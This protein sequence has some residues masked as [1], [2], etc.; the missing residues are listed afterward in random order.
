MNLTTR[1]FIYAPFAVFV[2]LALGLSV[3]WWIAA[4]DYAARLDRANGREIAPSVTLHFASK[5]VG[6]FPFR[7]DAVFKNIEI[8]VATPHGPASWRAPDFAMHALTYGRDQTL[9][10]AAGRQEL[11][12]TG[13]DGRR[14]TLDFVPGALRASAILKDGAVSRFDLEIINWGSAA[15]TAA[16]AQLHL[17]RNPSHDAIDLFITAG[18][19]HLPPAERSAFGNEI[20]SAS[21]SVTI[22]PGGAFNGLRAGKSDWLQAV[23][24]WRGLSGGAHIDHVEIAWDRLSAMGEGALSL[25]G[26]HRPLGLVDLKFAGI[27]T[28]L[29]GA[30]RDHIAATA[31]K[32]VGAAL[33]ARTRV[34]GAD[35]MSRVGAV[36]AFKDGIAYVGD[37]PAGFVEPLY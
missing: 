29:A 24:D 16:D 22:A 23:E 11:A 18:D 6:G 17:R 30:E 9:F 2:A 8:E 34:A 19:V 13:E 33:L 28:F 20:K 37:T 31:N 36:L 7:L 1:F 26:A 25:D 3:R 12:W 15:F 5:T 27:E 10:E 35:E 4:K 14:H 32:G 21:I